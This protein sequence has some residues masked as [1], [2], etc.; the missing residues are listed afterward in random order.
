MYFEKQRDSHE[1]Y[2]LKGDDAPSRVQA[3]LWDYPVDRNASHVVCGFYF[4][5]LMHICFLKNIKKSRKGNTPK[6]GGG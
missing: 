3:G 2:A 1:S 4:L 5:Y 6:S